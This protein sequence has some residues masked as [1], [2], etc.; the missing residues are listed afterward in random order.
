MILSDINRRT[1]EL[2]WLRD[3][4]AAAY[5]RA[6]HAG[7]PRGYLSDAGR[8]IAEQEVMFRRSYTDNYAASARFDRRWWSG[9]AW[10]RKP[11]AAAAAPPGALYAY[12]ESGLAIDLAEPARSWLRARP[13]FGFVK[14]TVKGEPWHMLYVPGTDRHGS[15]DSVKIPSHETTLPDAMPMI[16]DDEMPLFV[17]AVAGS[18]EGE[19]AIYLLRP[20]APPRYLNQA[21]WALW[22]RAGA[23]TADDYNMHEINMLAATMG[24]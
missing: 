4:A 11:G 19:G 20:G 10:W 17:R 13:E 9:R 23:S 22:Y 21:E 8:T 6:L 18:P 1:K 14:D 3:D 24:G 2:G 15:N 12:H 7:M 16:K 5:E